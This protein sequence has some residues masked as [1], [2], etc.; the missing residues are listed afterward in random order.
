MRVGGEKL[1]VVAQSLV[2]RQRE[3]VVSRASRVFELVDGIKTRVNPLPRED[4]AARL[5]GGWRRDA[6][7]CGVSRGQLDRRKQVYITGARK[8]NA[9]REEVFGARRQIWRE[10]SFNTD[11]RLRAVGRDKVRVG[12]KDRRRDARE[13]CGKASAPRRG[14][15]SRRIFPGRYLLKG[16]RAVF[17]DS[18]VKIRER[19]PVI[20]QSESCS[21]HPLS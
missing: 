18:A 20:E 17:L 10:E 11:I 12:A 3:A 19:Q 9:A 14:K 1:H 13:W 16:L 15:H 4:Q 2:E 21:H 8:M 6:E 5:L 7:R